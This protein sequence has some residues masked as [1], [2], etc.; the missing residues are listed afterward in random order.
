[1]AAG[2]GCN[3]C[4]PDTVGVYSV[5]IMFFGYTGHLVSALCGSYLVR[6]LALS[7]R[8]PIAVLAAS[9][10]FTWFPIWAAGGSISHTL[11]PG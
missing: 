3:V 7:T 4:R 6:G 10:G 8:L 1:M 5:L 11:G 9:V 2:R